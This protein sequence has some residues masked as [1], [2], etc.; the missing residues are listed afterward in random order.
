MI[1]SYMYI[2]LLDLSALPQAYIEITAGI[3]VQIVLIFFLFLL[4]TTI[5]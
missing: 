3:I 4:S 5:W 1:H 2:Y